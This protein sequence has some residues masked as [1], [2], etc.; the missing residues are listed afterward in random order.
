MMRSTCFT[1]F[2]AVTLFGCDRGRPDLLPG[3]IERDR[4]EISAE[5]TDPI[6]ERRVREGQTVKLGDT[7]IVQDTSIARAQLDGAQ[8]DIAQRQAQLSERTAGARAENRA[9]ARARTDRARVQLQVETREWQRLTDLIDRKLVSESQLVR[10]QGL[11]DTAA[12]SLRE[13]E[14]ALAE[15]DHGTRPEQITQARQSLEQA[16]ARQ[17]ELAASA[18]RLT[19]VAPADGIVDAL[20]Y[21]VG[22]RPLPGTAVA[23]L[24]AGGQ[25]FVRA[26][27]PEPRRASAAVGGRVRVHVDGVTSVFEGE[28]RYISS[29]A[30]YTPYYSLTAADRSRLAFRLEVTVLG[31]AALSLPSGLPAEV[32]LLPAKSP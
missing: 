1:I 9:A 20:P 27:I 13:A 17:R 7:L 5:T 29:E 18:G 19:V 21:H 24:L 11:R 4:I 14:Q 28:I 2:A 15:L 22:E 3:T 6:T 30:A 31:D 8:A 23:V 32:E 10:Q 12:A 16:R 26:Y 25:P